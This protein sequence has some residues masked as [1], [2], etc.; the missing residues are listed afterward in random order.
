MSESIVQSFNRRIFRCHDAKC[1]TQVIDGPT[2]LPKS[3]II[4]SL[5][6]YPV[7]PLVE[8]TEQ[9]RMTAGSRASHPT[10]PPPCP[11]NQCLWKEELDGR[12]ALHLKLLAECLAAEW[13]VLHLISCRLQTYR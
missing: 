7:H 11:E 8:V 12:I 10:L 13:R 9:V 4:K 6:I 5:V 1:P 3:C 2:H